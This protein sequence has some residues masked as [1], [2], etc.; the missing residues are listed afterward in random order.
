MCLYI[1]YATRSLYTM[2]QIDLTICSR[3]NGQNDFDYK[4]ASTWYIGI[5][6]TVLYLSTTPPLAFFGDL[7]G[8]SLMIY[9]LS[10]KDTIY[11]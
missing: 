7:S 5:V 4:N 10:I 6:C 3:P 8:Y 2:E 1:Q 9:V 11:F